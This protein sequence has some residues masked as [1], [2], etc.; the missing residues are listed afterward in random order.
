M[1]GRHL[2]ALAALTVTL[3]HAQAPAQMT[4]QQMQEAL[5]R[6]MQVMAA[7]F[8]LRESRLGFEETVSAL[9]TAAERRGWTVERVEDVQA[10]MRAQ[11]AKD[12]PRMKVIFACPKD[13]NERLAKAAEGKLPPLPCRITVFENKDG[14]VQVMRMHTGN[15]A[16]AVQG[17]A[18]KVLAQVATEEE[19]VLKAIQ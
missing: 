3:S 6:Q 1:Q 8:D 17:E 15:V 9:R 10:A 4:P 19:A 12:A 13:A 2:I 16:K 5:Q 11:G 18:A 7:M 14:K